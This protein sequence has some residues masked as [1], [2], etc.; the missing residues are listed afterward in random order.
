MCRS[1]PRCAWAA[2]RGSATGVLAAD[3]LSD[4]RRGMPMHSHLVE[5]VNGRLVVTEFANEE[6]LVE[7]MACRGFLVKGVESDGRRIE[8]Q[9]QPVFDRVAGPFWAHDSLRYETWE[10]KANSRLS[11]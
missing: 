7:A 8:L 11:K 1:D 3:S 2:A 4:R 5:V 6:E 9:G 10:A